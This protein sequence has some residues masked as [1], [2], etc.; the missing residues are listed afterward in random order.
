MTEE[1]SQQG[2]F[3]FYSRI[4]YPGPDARPSTR[5]A[6][7]FSRHLD[8][9]GR[10]RFLDAGCG[11]AAHSIGIAQLFP[12]AHVVGI[13]GARDSLEQGRKSAQAH[14]V[15]DRVTLLEASFLDDLGDLF[16]EPF[17]AALACG[18]LHHSTL[19]PGPDGERRSGA[20]VGL[21][22]I[23]AVVKPGG[24]AGLMIYSRRGWQRYAELSEL[25]KLISGFAPGETDNTRIVALA[26]AYFGRWQTWR[27]RTVRELE[28]SLRSAIGRLKNR[29]LGRP[30]SGY[31]E[32]IR[33]SV[34]Y[35]MDTYAQPVADPVDS[36]ELRD[37]LNGAGL[38][39][40]EMAGFAKPDPSLLPAA[41]QDCFAGLDYW[42]QVRVMELMPQYVAP[43]SSS[44]YRPQSFNV[45]ARKPG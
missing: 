27:D 25:F 45:L 24:L 4:A 5:W 37:L 21:R 39:L 31:L 38:E 18:S 15:A 17:D 1:R 11:A 30:H 19:P 28:F 44:P 29:L 6:A 14:G 12:K 23:A 35:F 36:R 43:E 16:D 34:P 9:D 7:R 26:T 13:D 42:D 3:E 10:L 2:V 20:G 33:G 8:R 40:V 32:G 41:W 22:N